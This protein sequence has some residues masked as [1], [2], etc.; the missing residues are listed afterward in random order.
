MQHSAQSKAGRFR[1]LRGSLGGARVIFKALVW[2]AAV[3]GLPVMM[4]FGVLIFAPNQPDLTWK[5]PAGFG[6]LSLLVMTTLTA[7]DSLLHGLRRL[8]GWLVFVGSGLA[9]LYLALLLDINVE[10]Q[11]EY[12]V[13]GLFGLLFV[14]LVIL[15]GWARPSQRPGDDLVAVTPEDRETATI[16]AREIRMMAL[17]TYGE[18]VDFEHVERHGPEDKFWAGLFS[19]ELTLN[20]VIKAAVGINLAKM[21]DD[22][23][24]VN[25]RSG[26]AHVTL[27]PAR[28]LVNFIEENATSIKSYKLG[29]FA[30]VDP[31]L[32]RRARRSALDRYVNDIADLDRLFSDSNRSAKG[33]MEDFLHR[34]G[35][36]HVT[37]T[38]QLPPPGRYV[39]DLHQLPSGLPDD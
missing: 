1:R 31:Q 22:M 12:I 35:Y 38:T 11:R 3:V 16:L 21:S 26:Q 23:I 15:Y 18:V 5:A 6:L 4:F 2:L 10:G 7:R 20:V 25:A 32:H 17:L 19:E 9:V 14:S 13:Y 29:L 36:R 33:F 8:A 24:Q 39:E 28:L 37:V 34:Q 27:P 30:L